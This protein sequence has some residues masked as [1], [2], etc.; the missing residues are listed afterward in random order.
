MKADM[1]RMYE[2]DLDGGFNPLPGLLFLQALCLPALWV[3]LMTQPW[4][5]GFSFAVHN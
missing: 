4:P 5:A 1:V 2:R 3:K